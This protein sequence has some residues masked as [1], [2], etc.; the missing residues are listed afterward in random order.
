MIRLKID[1][2]CD[3]IA[4]ISLVR[5]SFHFLHFRQFI[6]IYPSLWQ[7]FNKSQKKKK[8]WANMSTR[9]KKLES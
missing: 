1:L 3:E 4:V 9:N 8:T 5:P 2:S 6:L 7:D